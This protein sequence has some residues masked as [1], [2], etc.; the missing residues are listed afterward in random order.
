MK[1]IEEMTQEERDIYLIERAKER[2]RKYREEATE[3]EKED[4]AK[5]DAYID[6]ETGYRLSGIFYEELPKD[7]L[8]NLSY[9]ERLAKAEELNGCKFKEAKPCKDRFA[10]RDDFSGVSYSSKCDGQ[11]VSV[12]R[13]PGLWS[14]RLLSLVWGP[15]AGISLL[16]VSMTD[17]S[18]P[19][20]HSW[21]GLFLLTAF[22][23]IMY[24][25]G[26][27][28][29]FIDAIEFNRHTGLVKTPYTLFRKPFYIPIEDLEYVVGPEV[30]NA[31]GSASMQ[32]GYLSCRKYPEHYWLGNRIGIAG[33]GDVHD[34]SQMNRFMDITQP[35]D[36]Y[37]H[38]SM[39]IQFKNN[40]NAH[41]N[42]PF[43]EVMKKYF[44]ADDCQINRMEVW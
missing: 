41:G 38:K 13:S 39:E 3:E 4:F 37:Y 25:L 9:E 7:H 23:L 22:P 11:I 1:K 5:T 10:P 34:W 8:H 40:R 28:I 15:L 43:P 44:D 18:M 29:R 35:I 26:N 24:K 16:V 42:G 17:D 12:P 14:L 31:R 6:R 30:K 32:T 19:A 20:G 21:L 2:N 27:A 33:G 36:E